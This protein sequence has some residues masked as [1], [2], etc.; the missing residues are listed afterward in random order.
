[1]TLKRVVCVGG[2]AVGGPVMA[3]IAEKCPELTATFVDNDQEFIDAWNSDTLPVYEPG[4]HD[5]IQAHRGKNLFFTTDLNT[6]RTADVVFI[7]A[8]T[9]T[10]RFGLGAGKATMLGTFEEVARAITPY[11]KDGVIIAEKSTVPVGVATSIRQIVRANIASGYN[12]CV[13]SN[14]EFL[15][16]GSAVHDLYEP[17]R[18]LIGS[19]DTPEGRA[20]RDAVASIYKHWVPSEKIMTMN[21]WSSELSKLAANALLAQRISSINSIAAVCEQTGANV[22]QVARAVGMD[23][24]IGEK[25][26]RASVGGGG[27]CFQKD[28]YCLIYLADSLG[29]PEIARYFENIIMMND[30]TRLRFAEGIVRKMFDTVSNKKICVLVFSYKAGTPDTRESSAIYVVDTLLDENAIVAVYDPMVPAKQIVADVQNAR[31]EGRAQK[32]ID[33]HLIVCKDVYEACDGA[34][35]IVLLTDWPEFLTLDYRK[36]YAGM[37]KPAFFFDGRNCIDRE[38]LREIGF[39][40]SGIGVTPDSLAS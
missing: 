24:R 31:P 23:T 38:M 20:A 4:L 32:V 13:I 12:F 33:T 28:V 36:L 17:A 14:P 5:I 15:S 34:H 35:A 9:P 3:I 25:F 16:E 7:T 6:L 21:V 37:I 22:S 40:S 30:W 2:G 19:D 26:L 8:K 29:L 11:L 39:C 1:M 18:I 27:S 10:K